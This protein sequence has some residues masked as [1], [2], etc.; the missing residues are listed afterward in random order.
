M[1]GDLDAAEAVDGEVAQGMRG[2]ACTKRQCGQAGEER[3]RP[4][5]RASLRATGDQRTENCGLRRS[6]RVNQARATER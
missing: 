6:A 4:L 3:E 5:H 2:R 1:A